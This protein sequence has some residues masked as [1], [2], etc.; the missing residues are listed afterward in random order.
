MDADETLKQ[1]L[2][3]AARHL[4]TPD[5]RRAYL[6]RACGD[7]EEL[8]RQIEALLELQGPANEYFAN[9]DSATPRQD[10]TVWNGRAEPDEGSG[11]GLVVN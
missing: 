8:R 5:E 1:A 4:S 10:K 3:E 11:Q 7:D 9:G 2:F 6:D